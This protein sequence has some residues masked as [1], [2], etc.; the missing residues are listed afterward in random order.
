MR[1]HFVPLAYD[2]YKA[3]QTNKVDFIVLKKENYDIRN[4]DTLFLCVEEQVEK[5]EIQDF[6]FVD[7]MCT[8]NGCDNRIIVH[9][10][11]FDIR[12]IDED[13]KS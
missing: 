2:M 6:I 1:T 11:K 9:F 13:I 7:V 8:E 12:F 5:Y 3:I 10:S 4:F